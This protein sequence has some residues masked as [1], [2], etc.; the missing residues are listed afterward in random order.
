MKGK[1]LLTVLLAAVLAL[2]CAC[3][4]EVPPLAPAHE[5]LE[6]QAELFGAGL[7]EDYRILDY[8]T[9][10][11][12]WRASGFTYFAIECEEAKAGGFSQKNLTEDDVCPPGILEK[13]EAFGKAGLKM[14]DIDLQT[15]VPAYRF[16]DGSGAEDGLAVLHP[17]DGKTYFILVWIK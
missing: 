11:V 10:A 1:K 16:F 6:K 15:D 14:P 3:Q 12:A 17:A 8:Q 5:V 2:F 4:K 13:W 7:P 9:T